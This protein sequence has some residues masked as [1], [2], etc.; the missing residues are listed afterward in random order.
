MIAVVDYGCGNLFSLQSS[1]AYIGAESCVSG[2]PEVLRS[3]DRIIL[4]GVGAFGDA[5]EKLRICGLDRVITELAESGKPILGICLGMQL[6]YEEST[7]FGIYKGLGLIPGRVVPI[8]AP[9]AYK[10]PHMGWNALQMT[11]DHPMFADIRE[12]D[13]VY[14]VHSYHA[15]GDSRYVTAVTEYGCTVTAACARENVWG[16]QFH[17]EKSGKTGLALLKTFAGLGEAER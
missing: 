4:P 2:D 11:G 8:P 17:P 14:F 5:A 3:A 13:H 6:L 7:E 16:M 12:G 1:L 15:E 9:S 10:I